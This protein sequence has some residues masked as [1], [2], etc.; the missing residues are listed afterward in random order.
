M[1]LERKFEATISRWVFTA[2]G[3][4]FLLSILLVKRLPGSIPQLLIV[5]N[6]S[7]I[8]RYSFSS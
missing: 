6:T 4:L 7:K 3:T 2:L 1:L 5:T 8:T